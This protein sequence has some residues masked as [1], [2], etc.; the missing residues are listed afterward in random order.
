VIDYK[1]PS[2]HPSS[3][4]DP[5]GFVFK[6]DKQIFRQI[7][8]NYFDHY[9]KLTDSGLYQQ[10]V[11]KELLIEHETIESTSERIIIKPKYID[12]FS[13]PYEWSFTQLK[14]AAETTLEIQLLALEHGMSLKDA[15][16]FNT[17]HYRNKPIFI[18]T[19][20]FE[21]Y[22]EGDPW[23]AYGQ[24]CV[25]YYCP[26]LLLKYG[27][28]AKWNL[29]ESYLNGTEVELTS[30]LLPL[31]TYLMPTILTNVHLHAKSLKK[32]KNHQSNTANK[33]N[34]KSYGIPRKRL[35]NI[36]KSLKLKI[37][38]LELE[39]KNTT[40]WNN[41]YSFTN[42]E[43]ND[44]KLKENTLSRW[45]GE[46]SIK[47]VW[48]IGANDGHFSRIVKDISHCIYSSDYDPLATESNYLK[49]KINKEKNIT[50]FVSNIT[51][52]SPG[53]GFANTERSTLLNRMMNVDLDCIL[54]LAL[55]HHLCISENCSFTMLASL[56]SK[57]SKYLIV[58]FVHPEDSWARSL[59]D[60]KGRNVELFS[61]YNQS[62]FENDFSKFYN[63]VDKIT[64]GTSQRIMYLMV[65]KVSE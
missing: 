29:S 52:P 21:K 41:Y 26:L 48:D 42:Y 22:N 38:S 63:I 57:L 31:K 25:H 36:I 24:F 32:Y 35:I 7:N 60:Q 54:A 50:P 34:S 44:F 53:L 4:R 17:T 45:I 37:N 11:D 1:P 8:N 61:Y 9:S 14:D 13:Y 49:C 56:W 64:L 62:D 58:E 40:K 23:F 27:I 2:N 59:L 28:R 39:N 18:D 6:Q 5:S 30:K 43:E 47:N 55:I 12:F 10:L 33:I 16:A 46:Q 20:S 65:R 15:T 51:E 19:L 3:F